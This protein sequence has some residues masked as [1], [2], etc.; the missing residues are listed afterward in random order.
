MFSY[1]LAQ[2]TDEY[3][4]DLY[5][6]WKDHEMQRPTHGA[7][8]LNPDRT[9]VRLVGVIRLVHTITKYCLVIIIPTKQLINSHVPTHENFFS[10]TYPPARMC[11]QCVLVKCQR[12]NSWGFPKGKLNYEE[13]PISCAIREVCGYDNVHNAC[14]WNV[15]TP[16]HYSYQSF[17]PTPHSLLTFILLFLFRRGR[18]QGLKFTHLSRVI[19]IWSVVQMKIIPPECTL[20]LLNKSQS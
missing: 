2:Y 1:N 12:S 17:S 10:H 16:F 14:T 13:E 5:A 3:T 15:F 9:K 20:S 11:V 18:R 19:G 6:R 8:I 7:I 4:R